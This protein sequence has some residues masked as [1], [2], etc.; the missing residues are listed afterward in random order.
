MEIIIP[1]ELWVRIA[2]IDSRTYNSLVRT[3]SCVKKHLTADAARELFCGPT[4]PHRFYLPMNM[5]V[6]IDVFDM[7]GSIHTNG[8]CVLKYG[9]H[10]N[11]ALM[12]ISANIS[13]GRLAECDDGTPSFRFETN[14]VRAAI[15]AKKGAIYRAN[16][17]SAVMISTNDVKINIWADNGKADNM[18][19]TLRDSCGTVV[20]AASF[21]DY[22]L[23]ARLENSKYSPPPVKRIY[24]P[25][26]NVVQTTA[27]RCAKN[28]V[29]I[30]YYINHITLIT[31]NIL[32][33]VRNELLR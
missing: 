24:I 27:E 1:D 18:H 25:S 11:M 3:M 26:L 20:I 23:L 31:S 14:F 13:Y 21:D 17:D 5:S 15:Y 4:R 8:A 19:A 32:T 28:A 33:G 10:G 30:A 12:H 29:D 22:V 6:D 7:D 16:R 2:R 9:E